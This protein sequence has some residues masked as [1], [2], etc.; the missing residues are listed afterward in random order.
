VVDLLGRFPGYT[1]GSLM[2]ESSELV[3]LVNIAR[4]GEP[5]GDGQ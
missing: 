4:T 5:P 1:L 2:A 3:R